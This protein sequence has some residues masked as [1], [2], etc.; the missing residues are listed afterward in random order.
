MNKKTPY[1][2]EEL[3]ELLK[4]RQS[5]LTLKLF[6]AEVGLSFQYTSQLLNGTRPIDNEKVLE[7]LAP[8]GMKFVKEEVFYLVPK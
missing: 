5:G 3:R 4:S 8:K 6:A 2:A 7:Y 1:T